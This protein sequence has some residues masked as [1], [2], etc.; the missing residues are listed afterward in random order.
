[1]ALALDSAKLR[2]ERLAPTRNLKSSSK[3]KFKLLPRRKH[4]FHLVTKRTHEM[5]TS[6]TGPDTLAGRAWLGCW[7]RNTA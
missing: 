5:N 6:M 2:L 1:M 3:S 4:G 7:S